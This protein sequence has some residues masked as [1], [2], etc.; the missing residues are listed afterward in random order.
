M[1]NF[2]VVVVTSTKC[3]TPV[4]ETSTI[5]FVFRENTRTRLLLVLLFLCVVEGR[6]F[7]Y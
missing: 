1:T 2:F 6:G 7:L 4:K 5:S 3:H